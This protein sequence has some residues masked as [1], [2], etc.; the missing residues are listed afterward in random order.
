MEESKIEPAYS[1]DI[2]RTLRASRERVFP[3]W[4]A[5]TALSRWFSPNGGWRVI[6]H[7][8]EPR[9]GGTDRRHPAACG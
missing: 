2:R 5:A 9:A 3:A 1:L 4:T 7:Q 8:L 6:V